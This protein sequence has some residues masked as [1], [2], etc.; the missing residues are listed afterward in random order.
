[1]GINTTGPVGPVESPKQPAI[2]LNVL[3]SIVSKISSTTGSSTTRSSTTSSTRTTSATSIPTSTH[4]TSGSTSPAASK[5]APPPM[6]I[7]LTSNSSGA[8]LSMFISVPDIVAPKPS[9]QILST[10]SPNSMSAGSHA[11]S[12]SSPLTMT[13]T[14]K[15]V[16][17]TLDFD[18]SKADL[19][20]T[21][22]MDHTT[23]PKDIL[24][25]GAIV[26]TAIGLLFVLAASISVFMLVYRRR[27]RVVMENLCRVSPLLVNDGLVHELGGVTTI[28]NGMAS[29]QEKGRYDHTNPINEPEIRQSSFI[30]GP[31][32]LFLRSLALVTPRGDVDSQDDMR[33]TMDTTMIGRM[34]EHIHHLESQLAGDGFSDKPPPPYYQKCVVRIPVLK[35]N[36]VERFSVSIVFL[37]GY[38]IGNFAVPFIW[39]AKS[40]ALSATFE[41]YLR[42]FDQIWPVCVQNDILCY[43]VFGFY[44]LSLNVTSNILA[45]SSEFIP[46][47]SVI[48]HLREITLLE[49]RF[50][51]AYG[52]I[53]ACAEAQDGKTATGYVKKADSEKVPLK[54]VLGS[55]VSATG[56][57]V[58]AESRRRQACP[59]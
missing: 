33:V 2:T 57:T 41:V 51:G 29:P 6:A 36:D 56:I 22:A 13:S 30:S 54:L 46:I 26:G 42:Q 11:T 59:M 15:F 39:K 1:M 24:S 55:Q 50:H 38:V 18:S 27:H 12:S 44:L 47:I 28:P 48:I 14:M 58:G 40:P 45:I 53:I 21:S 16:L 9:K 20:L 5:V 7:S 31:D 32:P 10:S 8:Y 3:S 37:F 19:F 43:F 49:T 52:Y 34:A 4:G 23:T 17:S 35:V 25:T